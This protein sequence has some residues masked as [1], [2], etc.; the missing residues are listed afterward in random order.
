MFGI[1]LPLNQ[2]FPIL[3]VMA[4]GLLASSNVMAAEEQTI[5]AF[6]TWQGQGVA[7]ETG[8]HTNTFVGS[9]AGPLFV[10]TE[11]G[12][13]S[14][15][16]IVCPAMMEIERES[17]RQ[18]GWGKCTVIGDD[19]AKVFGRWSCEGVHLVGC[20]GNITLTGGTGRMAGTTGE[21][22]VRVRTTTR[23]AASDA[24]ASGSTL[25]LGAGI[26]IIRDLT[27]A[28]PSM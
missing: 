2:N 6:A 12:P 25:E 24:S 8:E 27:Y 1:T 22:K 26:L 19:G 23:A 3:A 7:Y 4:A 11:K 14:A 9:I 10:D 16:R 21:G 15:G 5:S 17:A 18:I 20:D 28:L 13:V